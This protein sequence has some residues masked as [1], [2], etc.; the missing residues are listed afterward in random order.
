MVSVFSAPPSSQGETLGE[1]ISF[2]SKS[3]TTEFFKFSLGS[4]AATDSEGSLDIIASLLLASLKLAYS[5]SLASFSASSFFFFF[6]DT[7]AAYARESCSISVLISWRMRAMSS[8]SK[9][10]SGLPVIRP[11]N[12]RLPTFLS[13]RPTPASA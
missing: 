10:N 9:S 7:Y 4:F 5:S 2:S 11:P 3:S 12:G 1:E 6:Q 8:I 13:A